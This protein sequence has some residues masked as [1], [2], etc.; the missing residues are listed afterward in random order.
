MI[1]KSTVILKGCVQ[2]PELNLS[3]IA[4]EITV[5]YGK[6][7]FV[8][9]QTKSRMD[10]VGLSVPPDD[11]SWM[12]LLITWEAWCLPEGLG[13]SQELGPWQLYEIQRGQGHLGWANSCSQ[14]G[15]W[16]EQIERKAERKYL[17]ETANEKLFVGQ[18][19]ALAAWKNLGWVKRS[20]AIRLREM[21][22]PL[23]LSSETLPGILHPDLALPAE[24]EHGPTQVHPEVDCEDDQR[25]GT[26]LLWWQ[27]ERVVQT[28]EEKTIDL[29]TAFQCLNGI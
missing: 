17:G 5:L 8:N 16:I 28:E 2:N 7:F 19:C 1:C 20:M 22:L 11:T 29:Q 25:A 3:I 18:W 12:V 4:C 24:E 14:Y 9:T 23:L 21:I 15:M 10:G 6:G 27:A 26:H 13:Q